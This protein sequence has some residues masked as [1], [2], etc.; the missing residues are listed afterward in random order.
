MAGIQTQVRLSPE[1]GCIT[2]LLRQLW[3]QLASDLCV[4]HV[5]YHGQRSGLG[6]KDV[7]AVV[8]E[9]N[10]AWTQIEPACLH[11]CDQ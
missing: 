8:E 4:T 9:I 11:L 1:F 10:C 5:G 3:N 7:C 6:E 2:S